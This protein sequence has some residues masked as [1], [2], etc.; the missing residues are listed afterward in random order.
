MDIHKV[1]FFLSFVALKAFLDCRA[2]LNVSELHHLTSN[3][4]QFL[5]AVARCSC[6]APAAKQCEKEKTG[7]PKPLSK[8]HRWRTIERGHVFLVLICP[9][10]DKQFSESRNG[11][12][13]KKGEVTIM[14]A[15]PYFPGCGR[16]TRMQPLKKFLGRSG[17]RKGT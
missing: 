1:L 7:R 13:S 4:P 10:K 12:S 9:V 2:G 5:P 8:T 16:T 11:R 15:L 6:H 14:K 3:M 17:G